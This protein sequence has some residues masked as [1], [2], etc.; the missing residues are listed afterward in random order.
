MGLYKEN[1]LKNILKNKK[2]LQIIVIAVI[3]I[4]IIVILASIDYK[5]ITLKQDVK[6][7]FSENPLITSKKENT[8]LTITLINNTED[9]LENVEINV[10]NIEDTFKIFCEN[11]KQDPKKVFIEK[12]SKGNQ[13]KVVCDVR[14]DASKEF[15]EG[16]Y[17]FEVKY[18]INNV[19][20]TKRTTLKIKR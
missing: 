3:L 13:R 16:D 12:I 10:E 4:V 17:S 20:K 5:K 2:T 1:K 11:S 19:Q 8:L 14:F 7:S 6:L 9:D 15:F 18:K